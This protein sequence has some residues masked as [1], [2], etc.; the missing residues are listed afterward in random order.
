[1]PTLDL[2]SPDAA[3]Y[4]A[5]PDG[6]VV[7]GADGRVLVLNAAAARLQ[8]VDDAWM[9]LAVGADRPAA[10]CALHAVARLDPVAPSPAT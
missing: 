7:A 8:I 2:A 10:R 3:A 1:M 4:D 6:V 5:L 9:V